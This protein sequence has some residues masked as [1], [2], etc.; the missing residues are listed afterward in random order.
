MKRRMK[1]SRTRRGETLVEILVAVLIIALSAG[2]FAAM[3]SASMNI[4]LA[5]QKQDELF[6]DAIEQ[7]EEMVDNAA[8]EGEDAMLHYRPESGG[9]ASDEDIKLFERDGMFVYRD[10][11]AGGT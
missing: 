2:L 3:Y 11:T 5:A 4:N 7:L 10:K 6:Y 1:Q 8:G 9:T